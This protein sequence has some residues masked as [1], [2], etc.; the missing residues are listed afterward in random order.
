VEGD[1]TAGQ[2]ADV[3]TAATLG[4]A[5]ALGRDDLG[6]LAPGARADI[7]VYRM[8]QVRVGPVLDPVRSLVHYAAGGPAHHVWVDGRHVVDA[9]AVAGLDER[10]LAADVQ[11]MGERLWA[12]VPEWEGSGRTAEEM[13]PPAFPLLDQLETRSR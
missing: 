8:D 13:C 12:E 9:G 7:A 10:Q 2:P 11:R 6:R 4:A 1:F 3:V 5:A